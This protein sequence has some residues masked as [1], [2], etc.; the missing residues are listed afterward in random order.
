M[1]DA[2][3][4]PNPLN[5]SPVRSS[6]IRREVMYEQEATALEP[7]ARLTFDTCNE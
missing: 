7:A 2:L 4:R 5:A 1:L 6:R 3:L